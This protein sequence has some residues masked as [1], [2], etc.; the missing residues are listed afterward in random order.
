MTIKSSILSTLNFV[1]LCFYRYVKFFTVS[2]DLLVFTVKYI[3][4]MAKLLIL[5]CFTTYQLNTL[6]INIFITAY[7]LLL[8]L[9]SLTLFL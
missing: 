8:S 7:W 3:L 9:S 6:A 5:S 4:L 2:F 1:T